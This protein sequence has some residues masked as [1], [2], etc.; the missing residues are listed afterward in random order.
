MVEP[1]IEVRGLRK[2]Y[3]AL[4]AVRGIDLRVERGEVF[5]LLGPNGAGKTTTVEIL[6]GHRT[7]TAGEVSVLGHDPGHHDR[8]YRE[9]IGIV[10]QQ[11]GV[12]EY[13]TVREVVSMV[14]GYYP[15]PRDVDEVIALAGLTEQADRRVRKLSGGQKRRV[16]LAVALA[17]DPELLFLDE[18]TTGFD[19]SARR[20]AWETVRGLTELGKTI[21]LTTHFMDEAQALAHRLAIIADGRIVEVGS[22]DELIGARS[23]AS[24]V[25][26]RLPEGLS[27]PEGLGARPQASAPAWEL[28]TDSPTRTLSELTAWALAQGT[29]LAD[30]EV[31]RRSLEDVYL[32]LTSEATEAGTE[33]APAMEV[34]A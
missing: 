34:G 4:E 29:E 7:R 26:F 22:A 11:T 3:G 28:E 20:Q 9:R 24:R 23:H 12:D 32:Q 13:L 30:L 8:A 2:S 27:P 1:A 6:E 15:K 10:L 21:F 14:A 5:A 16:D 17:G 25:R 19:P 18:P 31:R 33:A